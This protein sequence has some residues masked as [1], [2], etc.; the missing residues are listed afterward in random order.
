MVL[1]AHQLAVHN[2]MDSP[3]NY[4]I[5]TQ[6]VYLGLYMYVQIHKCMQ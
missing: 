6:L 1:W 4:I 3:E 2:Q 5:W